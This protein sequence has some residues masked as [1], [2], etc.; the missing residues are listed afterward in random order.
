MIKNKRYYKYKGPRDNTNLKNFIL[1]THEEFS[2]SKIPSNLPTFWENISNG[3]SDFSHE[4][5]RIYKSGNTI[6][7]VILSFLFGLV[8]IFIMAI[9]YFL[10]CNN[11]KTP[12]QI[13][14][15]RL[16]MNPG[17]STNS[18]T[19]QDRE[20]RTNTSELLKKRSSKRRDE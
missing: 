5:I 19:S 20:Y 14:S 12:E 1:K 10:F 18:N 4:I 6:A 8:F 3:F 2:S 15:K 13:T 11:L 9:F 7:I 16:T 17:T